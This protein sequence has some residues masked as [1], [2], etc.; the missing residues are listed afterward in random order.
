MGK[1]LAVII[2][3][4]NDADNVKRYVT[5]IKNYECIDM[6]IVVDNNSTDGRYEELSNL[7]S[8]KVDVVKSGKNAGYAYGNNYAIKYLNNTYGEYKYIAISNPDV[9]IAEDAYKK[10]IDAL[11]N[12]DDIAA[13]SP[14]MYRSN[15]K[16]HSNAGW[17]ARTY[18]GDLIKSSKILTKHFGKSYSIN[19][20]EKYFDQDMAYV[21]CLPG[22]F[23][24]IKA[25]AFKEVD[26]F[27]EN[28]FL[29]Y[30]EDILFHKLGER[31]YK[32]VVLGTCGFIHYDSVA[33]NKKFNR[34][35]KFRMMQKS[36]SYFH[37]E[38]NKVAWYKLLL[39]R[40]ATVLRH[41]EIYRERIKAK[42]K[43]ILK[44]FMT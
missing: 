17:K 42:I 31:G 9:E 40:F 25:S 20:P 39:I 5:D 32:Q 12:H 7:V 3:N 26:Y 28:T 27:D 38:Y 44:M 8:E 13:T 24:I 29:F 2:L 22:S 4:Y 11:E 1:K 6:I 19:Y 37:K 21:G 33:I 35:A 34:L 23:F 43:D 10:C 14:R 16:H 18:K 15:N 36:K 30:E 41:I